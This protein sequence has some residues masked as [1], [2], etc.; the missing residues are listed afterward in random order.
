MA[1]SNL[2]S[3]KSIEQD[4]YYIDD[5]EV[6]WPGVVMYVD[7]PFKKGRI[8]V[9]VPRFFSGLPAED[10]PWAYPRQST[11]GKSFQ[12]PEIGKVVNVS[13][14]SGDIYHPEYDYA[15]H[16]NYN[17]QTKL[18]S[19]TD[20]AYRQFLA[21]SFSAKF[22][23]YKDDVKEGL[24]LDYVKSRLNIDTKGNISLDLRDNNSSLFIGSPD[25]SQSA[26]LGDA[27]MNWFDKL[28]Q[29]LLGG[30]GGPYL[31]NMGA[32]VIANPSM[33]Q[34]C[35]EYFAIRPN[36][37]S[38]HVKVVDNYSVKPNDR[39]FDQI[40]ENDK[41]SSNGKDY[42]VN[43]KN[44]QIYQPSND[45]ATPTTPSTSPTSPSSV[46]TQAPAGG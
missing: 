18:E 45:N 1:I 3:G 19:L 41:F 21:L 35:N 39:K 7:D 10:L 33:L 34:V 15:E 40:P 17:L 14:P 6:E 9:N 42:T 30:N 26:V 43:N 28:V 12:I 38:V 13:F 16:F 20:E 5:N 4:F 29:N 36:F 44:Y 37:L 2:L 8:K 24:I 23:L 22:Q 27:F 46:S 25:A 31:G 11:D 32:P